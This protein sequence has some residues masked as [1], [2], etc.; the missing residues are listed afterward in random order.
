LRELLEA[1]TGDRIHHPV[2]TE[3]FSEVRCH[4]AET[5]LALEA[6]LLA[7]VYELIELFYSFSIGR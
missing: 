3:V 5:A 1:R 2:A 4:D 7:W 6:L